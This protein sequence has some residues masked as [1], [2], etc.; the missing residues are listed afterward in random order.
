MH[1]GYPFHEEMNRFVTKHI[2]FYKRC[3]LET[4]IIP[5]IHSD[6][7]TPD[8]VEIDDMSTVM[9]SKSLHVIVNIPSHRNYPPLDFYIDLEDISS[10]EIIQNLYF[11][12][13]DKD[14][15][16]LHLDSASDANIAREHLSEFFSR[17][18][19]YGSARHL[20]SQTPYQKKGE[21]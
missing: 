12:L 3:T 5:S 1:E 2:S 8:E 20:Y 7:Y 14:L 9:L 21:S 15:F 19:N 13:R 18:E 4:D 17:Y 10:R 16:E 11:F 6:N